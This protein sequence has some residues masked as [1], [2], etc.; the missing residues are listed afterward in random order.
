MA[1]LCAFLICTN[2]IW[3]EE[4][5]GSC[6]A[7]PAELEW[8][9]F[10]GI[11]LSEINGRGQID[12]DRERPNYQARLGYVWN[13]NSLFVIQVSSHIDF[14]YDPKVCP[15]LSIN[16]GHVHNLALFW[17]SDEFIDGFWFASTLKKPRI[18]KYFKYAK[19]IQSVAINRQ[20][21][22]QSSVNSQFEN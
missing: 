1:L 21:Y 18:F 19:L 9:S 14:G 8:I 16:L 2:D 10:K 17:N 22:A 13:I 7:F 4:T 20:Q 12:H 15:Y 11:T 6:H 3:R 5:H